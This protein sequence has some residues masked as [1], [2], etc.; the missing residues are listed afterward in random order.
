MSHRQLTTENPRGL[1][2]NRPSPRSVTWLTLLVY[3]GLAVFMT[4]P[5]ASQLTTRLAGGRADLMTHQWAFWWVK[6]AFSRG[7]NPLYTTLIFYPNGVSLLYHNV[8]WF[9]ILFWIPLQAVLGSFAAY[10]LIFIATFALNAF[11]TFL[12]AREWTKTTWPAFVGGLVWGFWPTIQSHYDH[13][14]MIVIFT[15]PLALLYLKRS[16][17]GGRIRDAALAGVFLGLTGVVRLHLLIMGSVLLGLFILGK[18][19]DRHSRTRQTVRQLI[20]AGAVAGVVLT[21]TALPVVIGQLTR[22][23]PEDIF[24][25]MGNGQTDLLAYIT[26]LPHHP[27]ATEAT[28]RIFYQFDVNQTYVA[29]IG[30][31][32]LALALYGAVRRRRQAGFWGLTAVIYIAI[33]LGPELL[34]G[35]QTYPS[36]PMPYRLVD[37]L[38]EILRNP[39]RFNVILGFPIAM[40]VVYGLQSLQESLRRVKWHP[41]LISLAAASLILIEYRQAP[42]PTTAPVTPAWFS[43]LAQEPGQFAI[44]D[45]PMDLRNS[46]KWYMYY[47]ITHGK[48][49]VE[50]RV[51]RLPREAFAFM[52][53]NPFLDG[54]RRSNEMDPGLRDVSRQLQLF[55]HRRGA[56]CGAAQALRHA[57]AARS[58]A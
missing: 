9:N 2:H 37:G 17:E 54:L 49:L 4:W 13:P 35:S 46:N 18:L 27:L 28:R 20:L 15:I 52:E 23:H 5:V 55:V 42:F 34:I 51:S 8:A 39:D 11:A 53:A 1:V 45:L 48:A 6:E 25:D 57:R 14:N 19:L 24:V 56:L 58:L 47:Q 30:Y 43:Q 40:L 12:L 38:F 50:G 21:P 26:P 10:N 16:L 31:T 41:A 36:V 44:L 29:F 33:A 32:T 22:A 3:V 7:V